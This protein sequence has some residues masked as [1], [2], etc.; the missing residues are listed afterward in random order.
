MTIQERN[1]KLITRLDKFFRRN[2]GGLFRSKLNNQFMGLLHNFE[3]FDDNQV[4]LLNSNLSS[5]LNY[6]L[7]NINNLKRN[8]Q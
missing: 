7:T 8:R 1:V 5:D 6:H 3:V 2:G 4:L